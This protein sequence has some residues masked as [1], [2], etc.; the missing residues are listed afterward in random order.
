MA[1]HELKAWPEFFNAVMDGSK[2]FE[3]RNND[4]GF[5]V[6][7]RLLLR[8]FEPCQ[9][10]MGTGRERVDSWD[11]DRCVCSKPHGTLT[12]R[13]VLVQVRYITDYGQP[14]DQVVMSIVKV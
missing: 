8:E 12:G 2:T 14:K 10:C 11:S 4:R 13:Y 6:G 9:R 3:I 7:D 1:E 5:Q